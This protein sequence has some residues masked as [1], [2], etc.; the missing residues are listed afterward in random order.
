MSHLKKSIFYRWQDKSRREWPK[1]VRL[2]MPDRY[3]CHVGIFGCH[4]ILNGHR[5]APG[6]LSG[7]ILGSKHWY[8]VTYLL[9]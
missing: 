1:Y 8:P 6:W 7:L 3:A 4:P 5:Q 9:F 2:Q